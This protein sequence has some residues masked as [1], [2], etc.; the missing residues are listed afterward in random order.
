MSRRHFLAQSLLVSIYEQ[1]LLNH[2]LL[3]IPPDSGLLFFCLFRN[4]LIG[5]FTVSV[6]DQQTRLSVCFP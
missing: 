6:E 2:T 5:C 4:L 1:R 3:A